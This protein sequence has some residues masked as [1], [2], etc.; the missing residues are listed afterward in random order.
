MRKAA[1]HKEQAVEMAVL[2]ACDSQSRDHHALHCG[3]CVVVKKRW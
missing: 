1:I 3:C 2:V